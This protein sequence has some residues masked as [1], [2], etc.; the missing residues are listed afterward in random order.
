MAWTRINK[1]LHGRRKVI[2]LTGVMPKQRRPR[3][4]EARRELERAIAQLKREETGFSVYDAAGVPEEWL[5]LIAVRLEEVFC[6]L[7]RFQ[8]E[9]NAV[10]ASDPDFA[11]VRQL[12]NLKGVELLQHRTAGEILETAL[13]LSE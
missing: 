4:V 13:G 2:D 8:R 3:Q 7:L 6:A 12:E 11:A 9:V 5:P 10:V 1:E